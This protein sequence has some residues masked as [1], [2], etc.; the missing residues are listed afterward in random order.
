MIRLRIELI[1]EYDHGPTIRKRRVKDLVLSGHYAEPFMSP[2]PKMR[3]VPF[4]FRS[5]NAAHLEQERRRQTIR[6]LTPQLA[7]ALYELMQM[8]DTID[9]YSQE[10]YKDFHGEDELQRRLRSER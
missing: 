2:A 6:D 1:P 5:R 8:E 3:E 9:G 10:D 7:D 4:D